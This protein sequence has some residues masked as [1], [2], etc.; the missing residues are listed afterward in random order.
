MGQKVQDHLCP[1]PDQQPTLESNIRRESFPSEVDKLQVF[2]A[3]AAFKQCQDGVLEAQRGVSVL[4]LCSMDRVDK[5]VY[6]SWMLLS[7]ANNGFLLGRESWDTID[8][9]GL[10]VEDKLLVPADPTVQSPRNQP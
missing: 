8:T 3:V 1:D 2:Q 4:M 10:G 9:Y 7:S 5:A 6:D